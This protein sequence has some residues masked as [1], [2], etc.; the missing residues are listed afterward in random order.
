MVYHLMDQ[1]HLAEYSI[2]RAI[3]NEDLNPAFHR[4][5]GKVLQAKRKHKEAIDSYRKAIE[6]DPKSTDLWNDMGTAYLAIS[7]IDVAV[8]SSLTK[9]VFF[10][11]LGC[12]VLLDC[13]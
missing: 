12:L 1:S 5:L 4:S 13:I 3:R 9:M 10:G 11:Y 8:T 2:R 6:I 7:R